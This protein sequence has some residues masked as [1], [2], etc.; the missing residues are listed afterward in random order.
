MTIKVEKAMCGQ[1]WLVKLDD[2]PV[3]FRSMVEAVAF[4]EQLKARI[5]APHEL[6]VA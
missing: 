2:Y 6:P 4:A 5:D 3:T 1:D